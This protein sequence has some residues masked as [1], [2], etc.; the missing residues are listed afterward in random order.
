MYRFHWMY[1]CSYRGITQDFK[2]IQELCDKLEEHGYES[3]NLTNQ[4]FQE[5]NWI[6]IAHVIDPNKKIKYFL[7][8]T[9]FSMNPV[10][11]GMMVHSFQRISPDRIVVGIANGKDTTEGFFGDITSKEERRLRSREF[12]K[13]FLDFKL[14]GYDFKPR[15]LFFGKSEQTI[16]NVQDFGDGLIICVDDFL[17]N[18]EK[19]P[20]NKN[21]IVRLSLCIL[22]DE[23]P[24]R[25][26]NLDVLE[27][28]RVLYGSKSEIVK[29]LDN[30]ISLGATDFLISNVDVNG[31][32]DKIHEFV[33]ELTRIGNADDK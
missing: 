13:R 27:T 4:G 19:L 17:N 5:D 22:D 11:C 10:Y 33:K 16:Q 23:E 32:S 26:E 18:L 12:A 6:N 20:L 21:I 25:V 14:S 24:E 9:P 15:I 29:Q 3:I 1:K 2:E 7:T 28:D 30:L 31:N 8:V